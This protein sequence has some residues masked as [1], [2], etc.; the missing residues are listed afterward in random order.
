[1]IRLLLRLLSS[2]HGFEA[3]IIVNN[4]CL[5]D[6]L[7]PGNCKE[8]D[9]FCKWGLFHLIMKWL[10]LVGKKRNGMGQKKYRVV[11]AAV[12]QEENQIEGGEPQERGQHRSLDKQMFV[13]K[14]A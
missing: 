3:F 7:S 11:Y 4:T 8:L 2:T 13:A 10:R 12:I 14:L 9:E 5:I 1:M 6:L